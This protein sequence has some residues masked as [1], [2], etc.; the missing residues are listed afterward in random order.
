MIVLSLLATTKTYG[1]LS[2]KIVPPYSE[3]RIYSQIYSLTLQSAGKIPLPHLT[4]HRPLLQGQTAH[5]LDKIRFSLFL[6]LILLP[7][8]PHLTPTP[9]LKLRKETWKGEGQKVLTYMYCIKIALWCGRCL[10][11]FFHY[12]EFVKYAMESS[13]E[14]IQWFFP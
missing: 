1:F 12:L 5:H 10:Q 2:S 14:S 13:T 7:F 11:I 4:C 6:Q 8:L 9:R 3:I